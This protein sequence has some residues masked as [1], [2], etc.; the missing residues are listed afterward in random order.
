MAPPEPAG[1]EYFYWYDREG[2]NFIKSELLFI[3][4][5]LTTV[6]EELFPTLEDESHVFLGWYYYKNAHRDE[7][8]YLNPGETF[9]AGNNHYNEFYGDWEKV[10]NKIIYNNKTLIDISQDTVKSNVLIEGYTAHDKMGWAI[11]GTI[12][13]NGRIS[14]TMDGINTKTISIPSGYTSGGS[15]S[16]DSTINTAF[17]NAKNAL[18]E[19]GISVSSSANITDLANLISSIETGTKIDTCTLI[20]DMGIGI[21][22][23]MTVMCLIDNEIKPITYTSFEYKTDFTIENVICGSVVSFWFPTAVRLWPGTFTNCEIIFNEYAKGGAL[24]ITAPANGTAS[25][26]IYSQK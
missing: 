26:E 21:P 12:P 6:T 25:G 14:K 10:P 23:K 15:V 7:K 16:L 11:E 13:N 2:G 8:I 4:G 19:K 18:A 20:L 24:I 5:T 9:H 1:M 17:T 22:D 3:D